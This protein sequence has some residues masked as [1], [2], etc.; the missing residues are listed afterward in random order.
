MGIFWL[1]SVNRDMYIKWNHVFRLDRV[2]E[3]WGVDLI[4]H[5]T[6]LHRSQQSH[7]KPFIV[8]SMCTSG[9][10]VR[11]GGGQLGL[12]LLQEGQQLAEVHH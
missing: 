7:H 9:S 5:L 8:Q 11:R 12:P 2:G 1:C 4:A 3:Y 6:V 10:Q